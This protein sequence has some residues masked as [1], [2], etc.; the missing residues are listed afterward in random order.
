MDRS[1]DTGKENE[2]SG[3]DNDGASVGFDDAWE[4]VSFDDAWGQG[5]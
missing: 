1:I 3:A 2:P 4:S 5:G